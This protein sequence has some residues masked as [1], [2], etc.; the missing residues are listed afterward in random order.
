[1]EKCAQSSILCRSHMGS[2]LDGNSTS[3]TAEE[4]GWKYDSGKLIPDW[5]DLLEASS[6]VLDLIKCRCNPEKG[7]H[8]RC[9]CVNA[10]LPCTELCM[11]KGECE[12][13]D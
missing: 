5:T 4:W 6:A 12:Q 8:G 9:K 3:A 11:C 13:D 7:C 2:V 1:M 10:L